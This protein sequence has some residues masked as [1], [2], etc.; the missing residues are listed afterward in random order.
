MLGVSVDRGAPRALLEPYVARLGL[1]F[2]ILL[3]ADLS[4]S[5]AWRVTGLPATFVVRPGGEAVGMALGAREWHSAEM[6][7]LLE[8]Y[9]PGAHH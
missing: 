3:D 7:A 4:A 1:S 9:L 5:R 2:P 6:R 8:R